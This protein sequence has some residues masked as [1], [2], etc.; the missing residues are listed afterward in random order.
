VDRLAGFQIVGEF[1]CLRTRIEQRLHHASV[2]SSFPMPAVFGAV[3]CAPQCGNA[4]LAVQF[5]LG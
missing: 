1:R 3:E 2:V 4:M 5:E